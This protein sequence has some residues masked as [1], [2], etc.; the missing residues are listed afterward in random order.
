MNNPIEIPAVEVAKDEYVRVA[1]QRWYQQPQNRRSLWTLS[2]GAAFWLYILY[3]EWLKSPDR[4]S[5]WLVIALVVVV[6]LL[7]YLGYWRPRQVVKHFT[8]AY[9]ETP[10][11]SLPTDY[12]FG[13]SSVR[14]INSRSSAEVQYELFSHV[15]RIENWLILFTTPAI[16]YFI[17]LRRISAPA[18]ANDLIRLLREKGLK[19]K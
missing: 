11:I 7:F 16:G 13:I 8:K 12:T 2:L 14:S 18:T 5:T 17:D 15:E 4:L 10:S 9:A 19:V 3:A 1:K 6:G